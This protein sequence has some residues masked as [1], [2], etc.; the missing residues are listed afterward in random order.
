MNEN[1]DDYDDIIKL[2]EIQLYK[3]TS[4]KEV[5]RFNIFVIHTYLLF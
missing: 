4:E 1:H 5:V 2:N 3:T